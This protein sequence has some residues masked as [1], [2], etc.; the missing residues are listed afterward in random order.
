[1]IRFIYITNIL[2]TNNLFVLNVALSGSTILVLFSSFTEF[3]NFSNPFVNPAQWDSPKVVT[4]GSW[5]TFSPHWYKRNKFVGIEQKSV[6]EALFTKDI[7]WL[8]NSLPDTSYMVELFLKEN[9]FPAANRQNV[10]MF[11][12][13]QMLY[14]FLPQ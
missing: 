2:T 8:S 11:P 9:G 13:G 12:E 5:D 1:M 10:A 3:S 6:Y 14:K 4:V 7:Y